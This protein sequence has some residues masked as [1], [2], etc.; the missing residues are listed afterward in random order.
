MLRVTKEE[1]ES[2]TKNYPKKLKSNYFMDWLDYY[3]FPSENYE[4]KDLD[5]LYSYKVARHYCNAF[6]DDEYYIKGD[7]DE[8]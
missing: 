1:F 2:Y 5:D 6:G 3:D 8:T 7:S 4:P